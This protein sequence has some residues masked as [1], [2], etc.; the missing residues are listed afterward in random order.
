MLGVILDNFDKDIVEHAISIWSAERTYNIG[1]PCYYGGSLYFSLQGGNVGHEVSET[2]YWQVL[3]GQASGGSGT[4]GVNLTLPLTGWEEKNG[5]LTQDFPVENMVEDNLILVSAT[6]ENDDF[7]KVKLVVSGENKVTVILNE[8][9]K[10]SIQ[11]KLIVLA[12]D[13]SSLDVNFK[14]EVKKTIEELKKSVSDGKSS[15]A[16]AI[17]SKG[18]ATETDAS[19]E[20]L[21]GN[22]EKIPSVSAF[23]ETYTNI[24][25]IA[26]KKITCGFEPTTVIVCLT[27]GYDNGIPFAI[28]RNGETYRDYSGTMYKLTGNQGII[29]GPT[30]FTIP[31]IITNNL[32]ISVFACK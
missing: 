3:M 9:L 27:S 2:E 5:A 14:N 12:D 30:G 20:V 11:I 25:A 13:G 7:N 1:E 28:Y 10:E 31:N 6:T 21:A 23:A 16:S 18:V 8:A 24:Q 26:N 15:I 22:I 32:Q 19:F 4:V 17:T 29:V